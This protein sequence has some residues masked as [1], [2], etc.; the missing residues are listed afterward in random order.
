MKGGSE[1]TTATKTQ[2]AHT[3][4]VILQALMIKWLISQ[5]VRAVNTSST[6]TKE[7]KEE[8]NKET[9]TE[10]GKKGQRDESQQGEYII[11]TAEMEGETLE[12]YTQSG[13]ALHI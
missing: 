6:T 9:Q 5:K 10:R 4:A 13:V 2:T 1:T 7:T 11:K 12:V 3:L 8:K